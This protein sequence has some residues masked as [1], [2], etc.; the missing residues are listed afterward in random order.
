M[1]RQVV[2]EVR[3]GKFRPSE[4]LAYFSRNPVIDPVLVANV[5]VSKPSRCSMETNKF[6]KG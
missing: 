6:G 3:F 4:M 5:S 2:L 1:L